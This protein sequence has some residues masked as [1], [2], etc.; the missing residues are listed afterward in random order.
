MY[1]EQ[2]EQLKEFESFIWPESDYG[3]AK[4]VKVEDVFIVFSIPM[5]GGEPQFERV[6]KRASQV[7]ELVE[8]WV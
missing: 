7:V 4:I 2:I 8:G 6:C 3:K 1:Q 5:Y